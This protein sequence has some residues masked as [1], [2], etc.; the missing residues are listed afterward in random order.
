MLI[1][2]PRKIFG[3]AEMF[4]RAAN[5]LFGAFHQGG[6]QVIPPSLTCYAFCLEL[7]FKC[8]A[9]LEKGG[10][11]K[12]GHDLADFLDMISP[13]SQEKLRTYTTETAVPHIK[14][15]KSLQNNRGSLFRRIL[16]LT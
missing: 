13:K 15:F 8:L 2:D 3:T 5:L 6:V 1:Y 11:K 7:Y 10:Y 16:I 4:F 14:K 12:G 9:T